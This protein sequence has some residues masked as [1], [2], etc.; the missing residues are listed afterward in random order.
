MKRVKF[1]RRLFQGLN[2]PRRASITSLGAEARIVPVT[3]P[4][5]SIQATD[6][7]G[8]CRAVTEPST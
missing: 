2:L 8:K 3:L 5:I 7:D 6:D 1:K 4:K